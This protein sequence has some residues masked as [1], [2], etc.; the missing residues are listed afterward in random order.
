MPAEIVEARGHLIDSG[1]LQAILTTIVE[2]GAGYEIQ[3]FDVG[4]TNEDVSQ[5]TIKI[6]AD[7][8]A[9]TNGVAPAGSICW[10]VGANG[11]VLVSTN[12]LTFTR[13]TAPAEVDLVSIQAV[14][15]RTATATAADGRTFTTEDGGKTWKPVTTDN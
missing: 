14:D 9:V 4:R 13:V 12:A 11:L 1:D 3:Q 2:H 7:L 10:L 8:P 15:G 5:L 6:D